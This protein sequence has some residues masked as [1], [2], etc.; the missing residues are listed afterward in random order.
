MRLGPA[1]QPKPPTIIFSAAAT[2]GGIVD[3]V[4]CGEDPFHARAQDKHGDVAT[5]QFERETSKNSPA[6]AKLSGRT[7]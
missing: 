5:I 7:P 1:P 3:H 6:F 4:A 2:K